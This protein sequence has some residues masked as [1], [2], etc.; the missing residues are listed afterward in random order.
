M[1]IKFRDTDPEVEILENGEIIIWEH[2]VGWEGGREGV[3]IKIVHA[4]DGKGRSTC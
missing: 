1:I 3:S 2:G 4:V